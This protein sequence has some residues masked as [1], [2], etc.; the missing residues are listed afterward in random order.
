MWDAHE[1]GTCMKNN[2]KICKS[3]RD[4]YLWYYHLEKKAFWRI[5]NLS[6]RK[7]F[8]SYARKRHM[9]HR[10]SIRRKETWLEFAMSWLLGLLNL[11]SHLAI[12]PTHIHLSYAVKQSEALSKNYAFW[13]WM[14]S[15]LFSWKRE[16][17]LNKLDLRN[18]NND[19]IHALVPYFY[20]MIRLGKLLMH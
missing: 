19:S 1:N 14:T 13:S 3:K 5:C 15:N 7:R 17:K 18:R 8:V 12:H 9:I 2:I 4:M 11:K 6:D 10:L 20:Y 16:R